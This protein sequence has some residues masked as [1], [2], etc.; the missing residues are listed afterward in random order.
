[1][2]D[3]GV[4]NPYSTPDP[5]IVQMKA[6]KRQQDEQNRLKTSE[7]QQ[8]LKNALQDLSGD[9]SPP[10]VPKWKLI[11]GR[12]AK[13]PSQVSGSQ[14]QTSSVGTTSSTKV[15]VLSIVVIFGCIFHKLR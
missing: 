13:V 15:C 12:N 2:D 10:E 9:E 1:M 14:D 3:S 4:F 8:L 6:E 7:N 11:S 5:D